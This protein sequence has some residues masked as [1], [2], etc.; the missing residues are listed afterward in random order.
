MRTLMLFAML[1][2]ATV[3]HAQSAPRDFKLDTPPVP[4][5]IVEPN[6]ERLRL[7]PL[8]LRIDR[9]DHLGLPASGPKGELRESFNDAKYAPPSG[10]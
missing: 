5:Q 10:S 2:T 4:G 3:A 6:R 8:P 7:A 1:G 9:S